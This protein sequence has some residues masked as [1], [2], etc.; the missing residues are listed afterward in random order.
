MKIGSQ[1]YVVG[2]FEAA[3]LYCR[4]FGAEKRLEVKSEKNTYEHCELSVNGQLF[5][6]VSEAPFDCDHNK[7][8]VWQNMALMCMRWERRTLFAEPLM[9]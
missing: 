5:M 6:A 8:H 7:K 9:P 3:D 1:A 4:A 2:S